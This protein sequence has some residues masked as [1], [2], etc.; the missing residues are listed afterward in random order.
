MRKKR[1]KKLEEADGRRT[2]IPLWE[3]LGRVWRCQAKQNF[4]TGGYPGE[5]GRSRRAGDETNLL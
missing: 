1:E 2:Y 4:V 5:A 3:A